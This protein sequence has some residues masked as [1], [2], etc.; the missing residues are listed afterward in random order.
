MTDSEVSKRVRQA[1]DRAIITGVWCTDARNLLERWAQ[2]DKT[3]WIEGENGELSSGGDSLPWAMSYITAAIASISAAYEEL[4][5]E[6]KGQ[7]PSLFGFHK[8]KGLRLLSEACLDLAQAIADP[9]KQ[10]PA[11]INRI[12]GMVGEAHESF[13][14]LMDHLGYEPIR[15]KDQKRV[16]KQYGVGG[17]GGGR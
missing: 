15:D 2:G 7:R 6:Q 8:S 16:R 10:T 3:Y 11:N 4:E 14:A 13:A 17:G 12:A 9:T 1:P 5:K